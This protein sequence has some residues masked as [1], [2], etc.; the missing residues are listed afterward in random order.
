[1]PIVN[2]RV[3]DLIASTSLR[4]RR[5]LSSEIDFCSPAATRRVLEM[6]TNLAL[7]NKMEVGV[8][9]RHQQAQAEIQ[10]Q[11]GLNSDDIVASLSNGLRTLRELL[12]TR[13]H[14]DVEAAFG[15]DS[16]LAPVTSE[17]A[18]REIHLA[19]EEIEVYSLVVVLAEVAHSNY[20]N[21]QTDWFRDWLL[22]LRLRLNSK[23]PR[24]GEWNFTNRMATI[25]AGTCLHRSSSKLCQKR[26]KPRSSF[27]G[28]MRDRCAS[29]RRWHSAMHC[30]RGKYAASRLHIYRSSPIAT[31][32]TGYRSIT[33]ARVL[34]AATRCGRS[35]G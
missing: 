23:R 13:L 21:G 15:V 31:N 11:L 30:E 24:A 26:P 7:V 6:P 14:N 8:Q 3:S 20:A 22:R 34:I 27:T 16:L 2:L 4:H 1:M 35:S 32:A 5:I 29:P 12:L 28:F 17:E 19:A 9:E 33:A 10:Q 18:Q 25:S